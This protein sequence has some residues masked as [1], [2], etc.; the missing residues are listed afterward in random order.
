MDISL[1]YKL[2]DQLTQRQSLVPNVALKRSFGFIW[3]FGPYPRLSIVTCVAE[4]KT[5]LSASRLEAEFPAAVGGVCMIQARMELVDMVRRIKSEVPPSDDS[6][7]YLQL[8]K[9]LLDF[10]FPVLTLVVIDNTWY[11]QIAYLRTKNDYT[12]ADLLRALGMAVGWQE[13]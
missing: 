6:K 11:Y 13:E 5:T 10:V 12:S 1:E 7:E 9:S 2:P 3:V 4:V 8:D